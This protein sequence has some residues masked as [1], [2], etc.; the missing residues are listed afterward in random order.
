MN[1]TRAA[2]G[3]KLRTIVINQI[4]IHIID[5]IMMP[6][7]RRRDTIT[8]TKYMAARTKARIGTDD[9]DKPFWSPT[10]DSSR[11]TLSEPEAITRGV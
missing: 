8:I 10:L 1:M 6:R 2:S 11:E 7:M 3:K 5:R 4:R 9:V